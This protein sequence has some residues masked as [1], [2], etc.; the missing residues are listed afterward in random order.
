M[1]SKIVYVLT[2]PEDKH[3][4]EQAL[5]AAFSARHWNPD[6]RI[7]LVVDDKTD[8][9]LVGK[10][11]ELLDYINE[12]IVVPFEDES[13]SPMYRS[14]WI[15]TSVRQLVDG[16]FLFVDC[17]TIC[18]AP[19]TE[20]DN[21]DAELAMVP[22]E[23]LPIEQFNDVLKSQLA[24]KA[25][26]LDFDVLSEKWYYN[27]GVILARDTAAVRS[28]WECWHKEWLAGESKGIGIDQTSLAKANLIL[29]HVIS[30]LPETWNTLVYM[31]PSFIAD[32]KILH[33][34][35]FRNRSLIFCEPFLEY[36]KM[37]G[38][39]NYVKRCV[40]NPLN[41]VLPSDNVLNQYSLK[42]W[43]RLVVLIR[44]EMKEFVNNIG[45]VSAN[46][47]FDRFNNIESL[48]MKQRCYL[49]TSFLYVMRRFLQIKI[50]K[51]NNKKQKVYFS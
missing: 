40:L 47:W 8:A 28:L 36:V 14:R 49:S 32:G 25:S 7:V 48:T 27:S 13:L 30:Q 23:H 1:R 10:R 18:N 19:L 42:R 46:P 38:I 41:S 39:D 2:C 17:D 21:F 50:F 51:N 6:D 16:D 20:I 24:E 35:Q 31:N 37:H 26:A 44:H 43:V 45:F 12:K 5:I 9:L 29:D 3:Y 33:F 22:D 4:I 34:W 11:A 15:K